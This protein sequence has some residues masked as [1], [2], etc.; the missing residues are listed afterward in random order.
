MIRPI[1]SVLTLQNFFSADNFFR[2]LSLSEV[3]TTSSHS[4]GKKF[5]VALSIL[6]AFC[7]SSSSSSSSQCPQSMKGRSSKSEEDLSA[8]A[9]VFLTCITSYVC[10]FHSIQF[11][12]CFVL[13]YN[14]RVH[15][16]FFPSAFSTHSFLPLLCFFFLFGHRGRAATSRQPRSSLQ[17]SASRRTSFPLASYNATQLHVVCHPEM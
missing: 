6:L 9:I 10:F 11:S 13:F 17:Q 12:P 2:V 15:I 7:L 3:G 14:V 16:V 8:S 5:A 4:F 1:D